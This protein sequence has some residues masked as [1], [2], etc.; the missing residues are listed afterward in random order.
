MYGLRSYRSFISNK[1]VKLFTD[2]RNASIITARGSNTVRLWFLAIEIFEFCFYH[3]V[4]L[5][6]EWIPRSFNEYADSVSCIIDY[7][8]WAISKAFFSHVSGLFG[9][10]D[11]DRFASL[12]TVECKRFYTKFWC[13]GVRVLTLF[14]LL[15]QPPATSLFL[16][17]TLSPVP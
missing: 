2:N 7:D 16:P 15:G 8:D 9:S 12:H 6:V 14:Q 13:P 3:N 4:S 11:M 5:E 1:I 17:Y 10:F